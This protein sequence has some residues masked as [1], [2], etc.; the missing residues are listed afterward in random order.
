MAQDTNTMVDLFGNTTLTPRQ[1]IQQQLARSIENT[2]SLYKD[3]SPVNRAASIWGAGLGGLLR[4]V[5][6]DKGIIEKDQEV[7]Q[8]EQAQSL[9]QETD[10]KAKELGVTLD[11]KDPAKFQGDM[12]SL[13]IQAAM[14]TN[15]D[16]TPKYPDLQPMIP[17]LLE[18]VNLAQAADRAKQF[19]KSEIKKTG[20]ETAKNLM[21]FTPESRKTYE[22]TGNESDLVVDQN[23]LKLKRAVGSQSSV[24]DK[25]MAVLDQQHELGLMDDAQYE[26]ERS[27]LIGTA[28][29]PGNP[30]KDTASTRREQDRYLKPLDDTQF[31]ITKAKQLLASDSP[32]G[33]KQLNAI[34]ANMFDKNR[35]TNILFKSN[36]NFGTLAGRVSGFLS[37]GFTGQYTNEQRTKIY[38]MIT[39]MEKNV[40]NPARKKISTHYSSLLKKGGYDPSMAETPDFFGSGSASNG[41]DPNAEADAYLSGR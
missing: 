2:Q 36:A 23:I 7:K 21:M 8:A 12:A 34:L 13:G 40:L 26:K 19:Q 28:N 37:Q 32:A 38:E 10:A 31:Q 33:D 3:A 9:R 27:I 24:F 25:K 17:K 39:D 5:L 30:L 4:Q 22:Q 18:R 11:P 1:V 35:A 20:S 41:L 29:K 15:P 14:Q 16:G 6:Q